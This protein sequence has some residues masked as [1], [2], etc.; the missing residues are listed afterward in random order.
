MGKPRQSATGAAKAISLSKD[1]AYSIERSLARR[2]TAIVVIVTL[3]VFSVLYVLGARYLRDRFDDVLFARAEGVSS[4]VEHDKEEI[5]IDYSED[6]MPEYAAAAPLPFFL[7]VW[8]PDGDDFLK[9]GSLGNSALLRNEG[10]QGAVSYRDIR[11]PNGESGRQVSLSFQ[12]RLDEDTAT[13]SVSIGKITMQ[14]AVAYSRGSLDRALLILFGAL[15]GVSLFMTAA[16]VF[17]IRSAVRTGLSPLREG[18]RQ[19]ERLDAANLSTR[20]ELARMPEELAPIVNELNLLL[21]RVERAV[22]RESRF[23]ADVAHELRTPL[24]ELKTLAE[25][26]PRIGNDDPAIKRFFSDVHEIETQMSAMVE[27]LLA[28]TRC[29][30]GALDV[31]PE[32]VALHALI[33][34]LAHDITS[35]R[36]GEAHN[37]LINIPPAFTATASKAGLQIIMRNLMTNALQYSPDGAPVTFTASRQNGQ[38]ALEIANDVIDLDEADLERMT[39]RFWQRDS[40]RTSAKKAGLGLSIVKAFCDALGLRLALS[41]DDGKLTVAVGNLT[42]AG[43][44]EGT[45]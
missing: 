26:A 9:S 13:E 35:E 10:P 45:A 8:D 33:D 14:L 32:P 19:I 34:D 37:V 6:F 18:S 1:N 7:Q 31:S 12:P 44:R 39:E 29:E 21:V 30:N 41:L 36:A 16:L 22:E 43:D 25:V 5:T 38:I 2:A 11:L 4:L 23:S 17:G 24:A 40:S 20:I 42:A 27:T 3:A 15:A 28:L